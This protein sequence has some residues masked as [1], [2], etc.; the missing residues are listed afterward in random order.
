MGFFDSLG[1]LFGGGANNSGFTAASA[2]I[3]APTTA[4]QATDAY[5]NAQ[6]G[7]TQQ[8]LLINQLNAQNGIGNQNSVYNQ[9]QGVTNGTGPNPAQAMLNQSTGQNVANQAALMAGQRGAGANVGLLARQAA[10]TGANTQQNAVGQAATLQ[11]NQ[12]LNALGQQSGIANNQASNQIGAVGNYNTAAQGEQGQLLGSINAQNNANVANTGNMNNANQSMASTNANNT[13]GAIGGVA[14]ALGSAAG[15]FYEGGTIPSHFKEMH[16]I[17]HGK[18]MMMK[19]GGTIPGKSA[20][21]G[22]SPKNDTVPVMASPGEVM[23]PKSVMESKDPASAA[24]KFVAALLKKEGKTNH[25]SDFR[26]ALGRAV[27]SR[28]KKAA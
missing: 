13:K 14:N 1:T 8:Q 15:L 19:S 5:G 17:Y 20:V 16:K 3:V 23:L 12:S 28:K 10:E 6:S 4:G 25:E 26:E 21:K 11:A 18:E 22:N 24:S 2:P 7:L 9:L 27:Q